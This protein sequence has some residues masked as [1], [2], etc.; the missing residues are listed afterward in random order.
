M[1]EQSKPSTAKCNCN[2]YTLYLLAEPKYVSC[3]R[4][5]EIMSELSHDSVNRFLLRENYTPQDLFDEVKGELIFEGGTASI[6]DS[7]VDKPY[8]DLKRT[9]LLG[10]FWSGKHKRTV[11]GL[12]LITLYS[13]SQSS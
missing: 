6:D 4:L 1:R 8:R 3:L 9:E 10:Y 2:L 7:V 11:K 13:Y 5:A 12:N